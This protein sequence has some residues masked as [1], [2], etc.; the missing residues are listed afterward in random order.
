VNSRYPALD[1]VGRYQFRKILQPE[2]CSLD[3]AVTEHPGLDNLIRLP[4]F[5]AQNSNRVFDGDTLNRKL[6]YEP[7][8]LDSLCLLL[9]SVLEPSRPTDGQM[10][11]GW[12]CD[13]QVILLYARH[14]LER[15]RVVWPGNLTR[16]QVT[17]DSKVTFRPETRKLPVPSFEFYFPSLPASAFGKSPISFQ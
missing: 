2:T 8:K 17:R 11:A 12:M 5:T 15:H 7:H 9:W 10:G 4:P 14:K 6:G 13:Y 3:L 1:Y 16:Q